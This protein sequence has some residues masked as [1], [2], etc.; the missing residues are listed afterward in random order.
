MQ[1]FCVISV[2]LFLQ[3]VFFHR[4]KIIVYFLYLSGKLGANTNPQ[5]PLTKITKHPCFST[6]NSY[7]CR[8]FDISIYNSYDKEIQRVQRT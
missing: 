3:K 7:I 8:I 6:V 2:L 5:T 4:Y 1:V